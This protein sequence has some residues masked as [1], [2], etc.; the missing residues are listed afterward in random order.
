MFNFFKKKKEEEPEIDLKY[1]DL[2]IVDSGFYD[3]LV[4]Y[5]IHQHSN[6]NLSYSYDIKF[7]AL[8]NRIV[9][10]H[11]SWLKLY[12]CNCKA[13]I[14]DVGDNKVCEKCGRNLDLSKF[15]SLP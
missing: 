12:P 13:R 4:G 14:I 6:I 8:K 3:G 5:V 7:P 1:N 10:L 9:K 2:I 15:H 11:N